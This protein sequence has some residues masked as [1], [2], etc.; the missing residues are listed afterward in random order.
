M[1]PSCRDIDTD[2][3]PKG[4][5]AGRRDPHRPA[6][7][8]PGDPPNIDERGRVLLIM[9]CGMLLVLLDVTVVNVAVP[10]IT[11][12]LGASTAALG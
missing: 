4:V 10:A 5:F 2:A 11:A 3:V 6:A 7:R 8:G 1:T 9:C 12:G